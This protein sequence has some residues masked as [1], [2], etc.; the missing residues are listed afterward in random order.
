MRTPHSYVAH[1]PDQSPSSH[2]EAFQ[3]PG[4]RRTL[5]GAALSGGGPAAPQVGCAPDAPIPDPTC[6]SRHSPFL[7][8][9]PS[10]PSPF[11]LHPSSFTM[12]APPARLQTITR[13]VITAEPHTASTRMTRP[14]S[15]RRLT[16]NRQ[17]A[18][19]STGP[20][21]PASK[22]RSARNALSRGRNGIPIYREPAR[23]YDCPQCSTHA[24]GNLALTSGLPRPN[25]AATPLRRRNRKKK[26]RNEPKK[27][28]LATPKT[29]IVPQERTQN[30]PNRT[31]NEPNKRPKNAQ[32]NPNEPKTNP[33]Q[34]PRPDC[35][36]L[37][38][39]GIYMA[40]PAPVGNRFRTGELNHATRRIERERLSASSGKARPTCL[41]RLRR[42]SMMVRGVWALTPFR[43]A[44]RC[45]RS[46]CRR[47][48]RC[49]PSAPCR[50]G[51][52]QVGTCSACA[53]P[54]ARTPQTALGLEGFEPPTKRL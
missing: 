27:S 42:G 7:H 45:C 47:A 4:E 39:L 24:S 20:K 34:P 51:C 23:S 30:E 32:T 10:A 11:I 48:G 25:A 9:A 36:E 49:K 44:G 29:P 18:R 43:Q 8:P 52:R 2:D 3:A 14:V 46:G 33:F 53:T 1:P 37:G 6:A 13:D 31:Q 40:P 21:T 28:P 19:K 41:L 26:L 54:L 12:R 35:G 16:A 15:K 5:D 22:A 38:D 17:N 50:A